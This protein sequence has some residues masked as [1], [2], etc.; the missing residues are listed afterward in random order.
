MIPTAYQ[1]ASYLNDMEGENL[2]FKEAKSSFQFDRLLKYCAALAN[3]GGGKIFL[4]ITDSR[5]RKIVGS[6]AFEQP[7]RTR[8]SLM[9]KIPL[10]IDAGVIDHPDGRV[11]VFEVP[12]R[13]LGLAIKIDGI[14]WARRGDELVPMP[15]DRLRAIFTETGVDFSAQ[16][17]P[18]ASIG[19]LSPT[20]IENF[21]TRWLKK[22]GNNGLRMRSDE[23][24]LR[25]CEALSDAGLTNAA[26][27]L[28]G[29]SD[30]LGRYLAQAEVVFEYRSS[31]SA[32]PAQHRIDFR[33]GFFDFDD[34]LWGAINLR[35]D[36]QHYE[37]GLFIR[38]IA[39]FD[40][41]SVREAILNAVSHRDY[42]LGGNIF[43]RQ[44]PRRLLIESP[45]G[46]PL[47]INA[48][49]V[50]DKQA[51][52][53][54][55]LADILMKCGLV[56][57]S[58]Q[59]MDL[60]FE[61]SIQQGKLR[62]DFTGTDTYQV[63]LTLNGQVQDANFVRFLEAIGQATNHSFTTH[64]LIVLD[65]IHREQMIP[66]P[67]EQRLG[68]LID[69]GAVERLGRGRGTRLILARRFYA[70]AGKR[71]VYTRK[72]GLD[73]QTNKELL[74]RHIVDNAQEGSRLSEL[75]QVLPS[76]SRSQVQRLLSELR[77]AGRIVLRGTTRGGKWHPGNE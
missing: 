59:G 69:S 19:D 71:G 28:L 72:R 48:D 38:D 43:I 57:R 4:G 3:E 60:M 40:E 7:E 39:T 23:Q 41:R 14:Y 24:L 34:K 29:S 56:E 32:G 44:Y 8:A 73:R 75:L 18:G 33:E 68:S 53:N 50:L 11:L 12:T 27:I 15:E 26:L 25:D 36:K 58:G 2:E 77:L 61:R 21:R 35:N 52:R 9:Q 13:P 46:F 64:D 20:A 16:P 45:G 74:V 62:P 54:R 42:Q 65:R 5:P 55:R 37:E 47:G 63:N 51:P 66:E 6:R 70:M 22:S 31:E 1:L 30:A 49:N 67:L 10:R 17:C 76:L